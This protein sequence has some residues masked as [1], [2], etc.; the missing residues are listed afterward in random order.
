MGM[1]EFVVLSPWRMRYIFRNQFVTVWRHHLSRRH[2]EYQS[3][4][5]PSHCEH[6]QRRAIEIFHSPRDNDA[7]RNVLCHLVQF[8]AAFVADTFCLEQEKVRTLVG[9]SFHF[10]S[11]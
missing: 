2:T 10:L 5:R 4:T 9:G 3:K 6:L 11:G 1:A 7:N 8:H